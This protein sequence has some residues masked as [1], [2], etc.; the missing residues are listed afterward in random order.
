[1]PDLLSITTWRNLFTKHGSKFA[2]LMIFVFGAPLLFMYGSGL[3]RYGQQRGGPDLDKQIATV[4]GQ[5]V[6]LKEFME[7]TQR[8]TGQAGEEQAGTQGQAM[9]GVVMNHVIQEDARARNVRPDDSEVDKQFTDIHDA[10]VGKAGAEDKWH[11][12]LQSQGVTQNE[13]RDQIAKKLIGVSLIKN[14]GNEFK[15]TEEE[16][17]NQSAE[18][19]LK[20]VL[21]R[22]DEK[23]AFPPQAGM[24]KPL[25]DAD[26]K[27]KAE[28]LRA[29]VKAGAKIE[30]IAKKFSGDFTAKSGGELGFRSEYRVNPQNESGGALSY[31]VDF[32]NAV[33][34]AKK[35]ETTEV[36]KVKSFT[37]GYGFALVEDRKNTLPKDFDVKKTMD[38][39]K[40]RR[41]QT[42]FSE[43]IRVK[44]DEAKVEIS[45]P[46]IKAHYTFTKLEQARQQQMMSQMGQGQGKP[47]SEADVAK[48]EADAIAQYEALVAKEKGDA[49]YSLVLA[50]LLKPKMNDPKTPLAQRD[51]LRDRLIALFE[52]GLKGTDSPMM[53]KE[54]A[55]YYRDKRNFD[56]ASEH[57]K[58]ASR[59]LAATPP[60]NASEAQ[61]AVRE[62]EELQAS[63]RMIN[64][65][66]MA[67]SEQKLLIDLNQQLAKFKIEEAVERQKK[68][69]AMKNQPKPTLTPTGA[70]A[71]FNLGATPVTKNK[72]GAEAKKPDTVTDWRDNGVGAK[73]TKPASKSDAKT[74]KPD[75]KADAKTDKQ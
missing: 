28:E 9:L 75:A 66:D 6:T 27:K 34:A 69:D 22:S 72:T 70:K 55:G 54:L 21:V 18:V 46:V 37:P 1:M 7:A 11:D 50:S 12:Y 13:F 43:V 38:D 44:L 41:A 33:H 32:D 65:L 56:K 73:T 74:D 59:L 29:Q 45:D 2:W 49:T 10:V 51:P 24:P 47:V 5:P 58:M 23:S 25:P 26:A 67:I 19:K 20:F 16:A 53:R 4:N 57:F 31:G 14:Y 42:K 39:I 35:G 52:V 64:K 3:G 68:A 15:V 17:K 36:V 63:F 62:H 8:Q 61:N 30:D 60:S 71:D 48:L 40:S